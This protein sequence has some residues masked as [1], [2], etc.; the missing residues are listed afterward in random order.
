MKDDRRLTSTSR[1]SPG[2]ATLVAVLLVILAAPP[3]RAVT[4]SRR[5]VELWIEGP[6]VTFALGDGYVREVTIPEA[7]YTGN[8]SLPYGW[9]FGF[10]G[11]YGFADNLAVEARI[12][13]TNHTVTL[14]DYD[15]DLEQIYIGLRYTFVGE[16]RMQPFASAGVARNTLEWDPRDDQSGDFVRLWGYGWGVSAGVDYL[17]SNRWVATV[18]ADYISADYREALISTDEYDIG[19]S[20]GG[21]ASGVT[22]AIAYRVPPF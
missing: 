6:R 17:L 21:A 16:G 13:Q 11:L 15:W 19:S 18:R 20:L 3:S 12:L 5:G 8:H 14:T 2:R 1:R 7:E 22:L 9:G 4:R 10:G